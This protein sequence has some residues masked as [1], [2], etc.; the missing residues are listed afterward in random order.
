VQVDLD[1]D[2]G[3]CDVG[4]VEHSSAVPP[5]TTPADSSSMIHIVGV[6]NDRP[7]LSRPQVTLMKVSDLSLIVPWGTVC[8]LVYLREQFVS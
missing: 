2:G 6:K 1:G 8:L 3:Y 4:V 7:A 5:T